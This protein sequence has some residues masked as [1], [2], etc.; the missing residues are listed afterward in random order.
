MEVSESPDVSQG[1]SQP[2]QPIHGEGVPVSEVVEGRME[3]ES[4]PVVAQAIETLVAEVIS[5]AQNSLTQEEVPASSSS[6]S[7]SS[8]ISTEMG[9][10]GSL[11]SDSTFMSA[12]ES[13]AKGANRVVSRTNSSSNT[14]SPAN[15]ASKSSD[16]SKTGNLDVN[17]SYAQWL[18]ALFVALKY[19]KSLSPDKMDKNG[20]ESE[21]QDEE[22]PARTTSLSRYYTCPL[23]QVV[24]EL[25]SAHHDG[26][27]FA[28]LFSV[29]EGGELAFPS[30]VYEIMNTF[31]QTTYSIGLGEVPHVLD[32]MIPLMVW[33]S[34]AFTVISIVVSA[35]DMEKPVLGSL[36]SRQNDCLTTLIRF[37]GVVGS[38]FGEPKVIRSHS[39]KLLSTILEVD[40]NNPSILE[41]DMF[42]L[43]VGLT[44]SL[45]SLFNG[46]A[47]AP[48]P[49]CNIQDLHILR[50]LFTAHIV[51][52]LFSLKELQD[53]E[54]NVESCFSA[55]DCQILLDIL[56]TVQEPQHETLKYDHINP[57]HLWQKIMVR[58][59][60][61][62]RCC[63][64]FYQ[65]L[66]G[67]L[68]P[69]ELNSMIPPDQEFLLL[70]R[71]LSL[72]SSPRLL[73]NSDYS[74][75]L[76]RKWSNH[77]NIHIMLS[78]PESV[79]PSFVY[80]VPKLLDLN[81]E[82]SELINSVSS[83][84]CPRAIG[85]ESRAPSMCLVCGEVVCSQSY[86][87]Q[88]EL[89]GQSVGACTA[90]AHS[91][92]AGS[93][94]FLR[95]RECKIIMLAGRSRGCFVS[96]PYLDQYG[97]TDQGLK[98][99]NRLT[100]CTQRYKK[101]ERIWLNHGIPEEVTH[102]LESATGYVTTDWI[103]L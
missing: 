100:L 35:M 30:S 50:L 86:C 67:V 48:L 87:C 88:G 96:P 74:L 62:L 70:C 94:V 93:G 66:S 31:C 39:L 17:I 23:D 56:H 16:S 37:C 101:L 53:T 49:S 89:D 38:N 19:K 63:A 103:H 57:V 1:P 26:R 9:S 71:Y 42:G 21:P 65:Y 83:F 78:E 61:F 77:P 2:P 47:A 92:G 98:R 51:Q 79:T 5:Q 90:H 76:V 34:C 25:E 15:E 60:G 41:V 102:N 99:G 85:D 64:L 68:A 18:E 97:E 58:S 91:C 73:L 33:Q 46:E 6:S 11:S 12:D 75:G 52:L 7:S 32:E 80:K 82:Y 4:Q 10:S 43:L 55:T 20:G 3:L 36:S 54:V 45:P 24:S 84:T 40:T 95:V 28:R 22:M 72:P 13:P 8:S 69:T 29:A 44:Y 27:S 59:L 14:Q 81:E